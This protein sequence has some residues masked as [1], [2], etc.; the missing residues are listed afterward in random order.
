MANAEAAG[1]KR[2][3]QPQQA[4]SEL[5]NNTTNGYSSQPNPSLANSKPSPVYASSEEANA[6]MSQHQQRDVDN[7]DYFGNTLNNDNNEGSEG[8]EDDEDDDEENGADPDASI[9]P[10][11]P[12][13]ID[14][15][16]S[17]TGS[18]SLNSQA[19]TSRTFKSF[20]TGHSKASASAR[21]KPT[22]M[23]SVQRAS[24]GSASSPPHSQHQTGGRDAS[25]Q[26]Q[27]LEPKEQSSMD[28][29]V[30]ADMM[31]GNANRI[32]TSIHGPDT[33]AP[34]SP[35]TASFSVATASTSA[36][37][38]SNL[39]EVPE[40]VLGV[41]G[42]A[43][44]SPLRNSFTGTI[45]PPS[46]IALAE[47]EGGRYDTTEADGVLPSS[48]SISFSALPPMT[49]S[50]SSQHLPSQPG[51][52]VLPSNASGNSI[53]GSQNGSISAN[54]NYPRHSAPNPKNNPRASSPPPDNS[55][56]LTL[57]SSTG[58]SP[59][60]HTSAPSRYTLDR[61]FSRSGVGALEDAS[62]RAIP[63]S[64]RESDSSLGSRWSAAIFNAKDYAGTAPDTDNIS[65]RRK[66][67]S[68]KTV[69]TVNSYYAASQGQVAME[70][71]A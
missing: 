8:D 18:T 31:N 47:E 46:I 36:L 1:S 12:S 42:P 69:A 3:L 58:R 55:S 6:A 63:P 40:R 48:A 19:P 5:P 7:N 54:Y 60:I 4:P 62:I 2:L 26:L 50:V 30:R 23:L 29:G 44:A 45:N 28:G 33:T 71:K 16:S 17:F 14:V 53:S 49:P 52:P 64:R 65:T 68:L 37:T 34:T 9:R 66:T 67:P 39:F 35:Q 56:T 41:A 24:A 27:F 61:G 51:S 22:T 15:A 10:I 38:A 32:A 20:V 13:S 59:S 21:S 70:L 25:T 57:A 11:T 43:K